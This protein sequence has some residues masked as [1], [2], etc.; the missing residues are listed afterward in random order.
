MP[1]GSPKFH[2]EELPALDSF[3]SLIADLLNEFASRHHLSLAKY[4]HQSHS[5]RFNFRHPKGGVASIEVMKETD[6]SVKLYSYWW[7]DDYDTFTRYAKRDESG[8]LEAGKLSAN[9]LEK[10][11]KEILSWELGE[12]TETATGYEEH[13]KPYGREFIEKDVERYPRPKV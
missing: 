1:N 13:W 9:L 8:L 4:Y 3:F 6:D 10:K 11:L 7:H 2:E 12:W 5:W